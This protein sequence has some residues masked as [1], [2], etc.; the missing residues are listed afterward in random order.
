[1][2]RLVRRDAP[3]RQQLVMVRGDRRWAGDPL[4]VRG[5]RLSAAT[6]VRVATEEER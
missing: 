1:M 2:T 5:C 3:D 6:G 4:R